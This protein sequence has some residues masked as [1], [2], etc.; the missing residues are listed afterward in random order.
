MIYNNKIPKLKIPKS[1][2]KKNEFKIFSNNLIIFINKFINILN[3]NIDT[4]KKI[5]MENHN[6]NSDY[7]KGVYDCFNLFNY[8]LYEEINNKMFW[9]CLIADKACMY[10]GK[11][12]NEYCNRSIQIEY[13]DK[14]GK[15]YCCRHAPKDSYT[16]KRNI[17]EEKYR[18]VGNN[19]YGEACNIKR[20]YGKYCIHH[21]PRTKNTIEDIEEDLPKEIIENN[22]IKLICYYNDKSQN[23]IKNNAKILKNTEKLG[24]NDNHYREFER[25][26]INE[27]KNIFKDDIINLDIKT[28]F[29]E[30]SDNSVQNI[31]NGPVKKID[32]KQLNINIDNFKYKLNL[33]KEILQMKPTCNVKHCLNLNNILICKGL[34]CKSHATHA[35]LHK[36]SLF[37]NNTT[38]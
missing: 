1:A 28:Y 18:C 33:I 31:Q 21:V 29:E 4:E 23:E 35:N 19:K 8:K 24:I 22:E 2:T 17:I 16:V 38:I 27:N 13:T 10:E 32:I 11:Y 14:D 20:K 25:N 30:L 36:S 26:N 3:K 6:Y 7:Y 12:G 5:D 15:F 9:K 37:N 34:F